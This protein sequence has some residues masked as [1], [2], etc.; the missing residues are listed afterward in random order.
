MEEHKEEHKEEKKERSGC[1]VFIVVA[2]IIM[3]FWFITG[4]I[5]SGGEAQGGFDE[6]S[7]QLLGWTVF[8]IVAIII[9]G[10]NDYFKS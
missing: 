6:I 9:Y 3:F 1:F 7:S 10:V 4:L 5:S 2:L 8:I